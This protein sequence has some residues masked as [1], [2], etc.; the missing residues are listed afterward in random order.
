MSDGIV[1]GID[2]GG[3]HIT[4][5]A[6]QVN[7]HELINQ[8]RSDAHY[9]GKQSKE[10]ILKDWANVINTAIRKVDSKNLKGLAFAM[11]G[12]FNYSKGIAKY[13]GVGKLDSL[14]D[15]HIPTALKSY[16]EIPE[17]LEFRFIN[18]ATAFAVG[19]A[20]LGAA[21]GTRSSVSITLGT[22][23]GSAFVKDGIPVIVGNSVPPH[24]C[25]W[26][27]PF[28]NGIAD[29][30]IST[31]WFEKE[32]NSQYN[33]AAKGVKYI[34]QIA[35][36]SGQ[37]IPLFEEYG[38]NLGRLLTPWLHKFEAEALVIGGQL[39]GAYDLFGPKLESFFDSEGVK[40]RISKSSL[41]VD[42]AIIGSSLLFSDSFW[43]RVKDQLPTI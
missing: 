17:D 16:L 23:F 38:R 21:K 18:D 29:D 27:L 33:I 24:G 26:H 20:T 39:V 5:A 22:G 36:G 25:L 37:T 30:Y 12:P 3:S 42:G 4:A 40:T 32:C 13:K 1:I 14:Y 6:L 10:N 11:P 34:A 43:S 28:Q 7:S 8:S 35:M 9:D 19:E 41:M 2:V 31:R 15:T